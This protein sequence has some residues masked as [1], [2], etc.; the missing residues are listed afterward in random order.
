M[1]LKILTIIGALFSLLSNTYG[2]SPGI[3]ENLLHD[4]IKI[5][6][7]ADGTAYSKISF[8]TQFWIRNTQLNEGTTSQSG[9][10]LQSEADFAIRRTRF[11]MYNSFSDRF[12]LY[13][14]L[15]FNNV[16]TTS[17]K[18]QLYFHDI[19]GM[20]CLI[21]QSCY[22]GC[23]LHGWNGISR[24]SNVSYQ[25]TLTLDNPGVNI[26]NINHT[27]LET[28][29]LG[30]FIKGTAGRVSY[31]AALTKPFAY[32]GVPENPGTQ[33]GYETPSTSLSYKAYAAFHFL[34]KEYFNTPYIGMTYLGKKRIC[35][36]GAGFDISPNSIAE[37]NETGN[38]TIK[39]RILLGVDWFF[40]H[41]M[42]NGK[43]V[44]TY[45]V[46]YSYD[47]G[48][49]YL[50][51]SGT[52]NSWS[53]GSGLEGAGNSEFKIGSGYVWYTNLGYLL[54]EQFLNIPGRIQLFYAITEKNFEALPSVIWNH[55]LGLNYYAVEQKIKFSLQ[56]SLRPFVGDIANTGSQHLG[57]LIFQVQMVI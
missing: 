52:I 45:S 44:T 20:F 57:S 12:V 13:T 54:N 5:S 32:N 16:C 53:G 33:Q 48:N 8:A 42:R 22:I 39:D 46:L 10:L 24:L 50:R 4:E 49:N 2:G 43:T 38:K 9:E 19:W 47:L 18:P 6:L 27:D 34:D 55:D 26:P 17:S 15:G 40:E 41:P 1:K 3:R 29:Q 35:N 21:P 37:F 56:Y 36:I 23:G 25:K 51:K 7:N 31:R 14:Q 30:I 28:R 11:S